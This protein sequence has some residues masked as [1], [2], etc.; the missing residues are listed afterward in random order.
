MTDEDEDYTFPP[1]DLSCHLCRRHPCECEKLLRQCKGETVQQEL[2]TSS[3]RSEAMNINEAVRILNEQNHRQ[4]QW[5]ISGIGDG[6]IVEG[7]GSYDWFFPFEAVAV[8]LHYRAQSLTVEEAVEILKERSHDDMK[9]WEIIGTRVYRHG[10][11]KGIS[12]F[13]A[14]SIALGYLRLELGTSSR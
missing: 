10:M 4:T 3:I 7:Y 6:D 13:D 14:I 12:H 8:A 2:E 11:D 1:V 9:G 5:K